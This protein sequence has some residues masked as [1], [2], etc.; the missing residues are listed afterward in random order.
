MWNEE[1]TSVLYY[2]KSSDRKVYFQDLLLSFKGRKIKRLEEIN[3]KHISYKELSGGF[4]PTDY[5][6]SAKGKDVEIEYEVKIIP[7][8]KIL[9]WGYPEELLKSW[10]PDMPLISAEGVIRER[11]RNN[12]NVT[13]ING[14][15]IL[16]FIL[17]SCNPFKESKK[18]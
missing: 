1:F 13:K 5:I 9:T 15:G 12:I 3:I 17:V 8:D 10:V 18:I 4:S 2:I 14:K 7:R 11:G 16:E 6:V